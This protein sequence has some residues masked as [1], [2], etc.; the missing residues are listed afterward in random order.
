MCSQPTTPFNKSRIKFRSQRMC[1]IRQNLVESV[2]KSSVT[3]NKLKLND[4]T[5][6]LVMKLTRT[7]FPDA[8]PTSLRV[9]TADIPFTTYVRELGFMIS[10]N[11]ALDKHISTVCRSAYV[12][13]RRIS[14]IC[15]CLIVQATTIL[16]CAFVLSKLEYYK[17]LFSGCP[18]YLLSRLQ[19]TSELG[20]SEDD[21]RV[22]SFFFLP[23]VHQCGDFVR[24]NMHPSFTLYTLSHSLTSLLK[25]LHKPI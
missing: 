21:D 12:E 3:Q 23:Q 14:S 18:L 16:V 11:T 13:I 17:Y 7:I 10:D 20:E 6:T 4:K 15:Q 19:Q 1:D 22:T 9:G 5:K 25:E 2:G 8:Q 24:K